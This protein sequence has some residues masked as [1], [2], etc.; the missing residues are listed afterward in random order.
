MEILYMCVC[1]IIYIY[2]CLQA[3]KRCSDIVVASL[4]MDQRLY[5]CVFFLCSIVLFSSLDTAAERSVI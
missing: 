4:C 1:M 5:D 3:E 2:V